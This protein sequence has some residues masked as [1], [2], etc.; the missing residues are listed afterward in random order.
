MEKRKTG[1]KI[2]VVHC[3]A[4][5]DNKKN[6]ADYAGVK[7]C[8]GAMEIFGG[9]MECEYGCIGFGDCERVCPSGM[10]RMI[11]G[12]PRIIAEKCTSCGRCADV[13]PRGIISMEEKK[14]DKL[15]YVACGSHDDT[16][17]TKKVCNVG[18]IACGI[19]EKLSEGKLFRVEDNI[20]GAYYENQSDPGAVKAVADKCPTR[21]IKEI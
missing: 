5:W 20:A 12:L 21:V 15:F 7:T 16:V 1:K 9:G 13:C 2:P 4:E 11:N 10:L 3:A 6:S 8:A 14:Y 19:C 18:C 17:R